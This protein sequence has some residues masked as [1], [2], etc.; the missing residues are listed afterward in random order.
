MINGPR[1]SSRAESQWHAAAG[2]SVVGMTGLPEASIARELAL[3]YTSIAL[4]TDHD[5]GVEGGQA[6]THAEVLEVFGRNVERLKSLVRSVIGALP[7]P[8][9]DCAC[10]HALDGLTLPFDLP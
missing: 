10:R 6:V 3:C 2:W 8:T 5:A 9:T 4:V 7:G 1:F